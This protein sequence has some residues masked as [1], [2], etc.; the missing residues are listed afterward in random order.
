MPLSEDPKAIALRKDVIQVLDD[1]NGYHPGFRP[2]HAKGTFL[3]GMFTPSPDARALTKA[4]HIVRDSTPVIVRL[5]DFAGVPNVPDFDPQG[6]SP[7]GF[8]IRFQLGEHE[9]TDIVAH[10]AEGFPVRTAQEF[11]EFLRAV[12]RSG[13]DAPKPAPIQAY[14]GTHPKAL[15]YVQIPKPIPA[16]FAKE[17]FFAV[18]AFKFTNSEDIDQYGRYRILPEE[19][20]EYLNPEE[21][22]AKGPD[23]LFEE[24]T[25]RL[26]RGPVRYRI[27]IRLA[28]AGD[29]VDDA[30]AQ[31][32]PDRQHAEFG[33]VTLTRE[34]P[35]SDADAR[36]IIFD[37]IPRVEGIE[38]SGD[39]LFEPRADVYLASGR[40]RR[41]AAG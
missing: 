6:A 17:S 27:T 15:Q 13:P 16:S 30:T 5:S 40:R 36:R 21:A 3:S 33:L 29:P 28:A 41:A 9:H 24:L 12:Q 22:A 37:P 20:S 8:A 19:Q 10:S 18:S 31:W 38:P 2:A 14:L 7:R 25:K 35:P 39:P 4:P 32:P 23:F 1:L 34:I 11:I 26:Q